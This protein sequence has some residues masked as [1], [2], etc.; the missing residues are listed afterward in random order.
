MRMKERGIVMINY[1]SIM[2]ILSIMSFFV[3]WFEYQNRKANY[4]YM[5]VTMIM[6]VANAGY[7]AVSL[8]TSVEEVILAN[9][10]LYLGSCFVPP[11]ILSLICSLI[12]YR[13]RLWM[14]SMLYGASIFI[15]GMVLTIGYNDLYYKDVYL[16]SYRDATVIGHTYGIGHTFFYLFLVGHIVLE[17]CMIARM[18]MRR[19]SVSKRNLLG[20]SIIVTVN[21]YLFMVGKYINPLIETTPLTYA[22]TGGILVY[23]FKKGI[24]YDF[25]DSISN[26]QKRDTNAYIMLDEH[27]NFLGCNTMAEWIF[28]QLAESIVDK[29]LDNEMA[30]QYILGWLQQYDK[31]IEKT[32]AYETENAHYVCEIERLYH[33]GIHRG[34]MVEMRDNTNEWKYL[35]LISSHSEELEYEVEKQYRIAKEL[36]FAKIEAESAN[37]AKS[38]FLARMSHEIRTPINAI[39]GMNEMVLRESEEKETKKYAHDIRN[40]AETLL[41]MVNEI[42][43]TSKIDAGMMEI[44]PAS[45]EISSLLNDLYNIIGVKARSKNLELVFDIDSKI[46]SEYYGDDVRIKQ[47]L[48]NLLNNAVKYTNEGKV[49]MHISCSIEGT[50]GVLHCKVIDTGIGIKEEDIDK[51]FE[52]FERVEKDKNRNIEGT[53]LG[54]NIA[55]RLLELMG[56]KLKVKSEY[57]K[58]SEFYF[59]LK[60]KI[61]NIEPFGEFQER[62]VQT[63]EKEEEQ[64]SYIAPEAKVLVVDDN[65]MNR[66][67]FA[68]LLK[69]TQIKVHQATSGEEC[70]AVL[71]QQKFDLIFLDHMMPGM[72]G[73]E[74]F[75][76]IKKKNLCEDTPVIMFTANAMMGEKEKYLNEG[77]KDFLAKPVIPEK[78]DDMIIKYLSKEL[79]EVRKAEKSDGSKNNLRNFPQIDEFDFGYALGLLKSEELL[80]QSLENFRD[81][82]N[83]IPGKLLGYLKSIEQEE[84]LSNYR[85]E[86]HALKGTAATVGALLLSK[87]ARLLEVAA[88]NSEIEKIMVL[89]PILLEEIEK[90][91]SRVSVL[92]PEEKQKLESKELIESY[93]DMLS[94][95]LL[96]EDYDTADFVM[97]EIKKYQY[98]EELQ[99]LIDELIG[100]VLNMEAVNAVETLEKVKSF[101]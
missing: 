46:P 78:L 99:L 62:I 42:L 69:Q 56:S 84:N 34:Y 57:G 36:E 16:K 44:V 43:D 63:E 70:I 74:T 47:V 96:Q 93:L 35:N 92:F 30:A 14:K 41:G 60:Q 77:F 29:P 65:F 90:H 86:V 20:I 64:I 13:M 10:I 38:Q 53:G 37:E 54:L 4:R 61:V 39:I 97:E 91:R 73:L 11:V 19:R 6:M 18:V 17:I 8:S 100:Q 15:Y 2:F 49:T 50:N 79:V 51:L 26:S 67:V 22:I 88:S 23:M 1:Y 5:V 58:G 3:I 71:H 59:D 83:Y 55:S 87:T 21:V 52:K 89:N 81:M 68:G 25:D 76:I 85:I 95:G 33:K 28:P 48:I 101:L 45:Y 24:I 7:L 82:L 66:N 31:G 40:A 27:L 98:P 12:N 72:D 32:F 9:K 75:R 80:M 94:I